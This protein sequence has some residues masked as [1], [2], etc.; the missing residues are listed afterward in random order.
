MEILTQAYISTTGYSQ[1]LNI[2]MARPRTAV[3]ELAQVSNEYQ[4]ESGVTELAQP[5]RVT[6]HTLFAVHPVYFKL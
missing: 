5:S 1:V 3:I 2:R 4:L 6:K